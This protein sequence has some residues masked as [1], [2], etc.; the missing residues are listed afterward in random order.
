VCPPTEHSIQRILK[1]VG[2]DHFQWIYLGENVSTATSIEKLIDDRGE[3]INIAA[4]LQETAALLRQPYIEYIGELSVWNH[5]LLWWAGSLSEK[6]PFI[7]KTF[8][9]SC[10]IK[11]ALS[12][13]G[14]HT[15]EDIV[16]FVE[17]R[18][19]RS[20]LIK[21]IRSMMDI[22]A[23]HI[24]P[25]SESVNHSLND[26]RDFIV[27]HGYFVLNNIYRIVLAKH[28]YRLNKIQSTKESAD[29]ENL[30][31]IYTWVDQR[32]FTEYSTFHD[33]YFGNLSRRMEEKGKHVYIVPYI[34]H[35][36]SFKETIKKLIRCRGNF[37]VPSAYLKVSDIFRVLKTTL[38]L[39]K[40]EK[41][42]YFEDMDISDLIHV[43]CMNDWKD[44]RVASNLLIYYLVKNLSEQ[45]ISIERII[46]PYENHTWEK[47]YCMAL[48]TFFPLA[49]IIGHQHSTLSSMLANYFFSEKEL[50]IIPFPDRIVTNGKY[51]ENFLLNSGYDPTKLVCGGAIRYEYVLDLLKQN[52]LREKQTDDVFTIMVTP[53]IDLNEASEL[54]LKALNALASLDFCNIIL[55]YHPLLPYEK[56]AYNLNITSLPTNFT[57]SNQSVSHLLKKSDILMY[58]NST[59]CIEALAFGIP[60]LHIA[61]DFVIDCD[62]LDSLPGICSSARTKEEIRNN[63]CELLEMNP[64]ELYNKKMVAREIVTDFFGTVDDAVFGLFIEK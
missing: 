54:T 55:K 31:L 58:T 47:M 14:S 29:N 20:G 7:S 32:S 12:L 42:P 27:K 59:T 30:S 16:F 18:G 48:R 63:V 17:N 37:L 1:I 9:Y 25:K 23:T 35:T 44:T 62:I 45:G 6:N 11:V 19:L 53:S 28:I 15:Q 21:N 10:Y 46:Y 49:N 40:K 22:R 51:T 41:H 39:P 43:N 38:N 60:V 34:L 24:E 36:V 50:D 8:L 61:S 52:D 56:V 57:V 4:L 2:K 3:R 26:W 5:S 33:A 64:E 13:V